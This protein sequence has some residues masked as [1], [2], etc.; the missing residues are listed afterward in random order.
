MKNRGALAGC[1]LISKK[2]GGC[3]GGGGSG[4]GALSYQAPSSDSPDSAA[5]KAYRAEISP[6]HPEISSAADFCTHN[7]TKCSGPAKAGGWGG[8]ERLQC[9]RV[10]LKCRSVLL[11]EEATSPNFLLQGGTRR[12]QPSHAESGGRESGGNASRVKVVI[13]ASL[14]KCTNEQLMGHGNGVFSTQPSL[15]RLSCE[16]QCVFHAGPFHWHQRPQKIQR[17][18]DSQ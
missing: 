7:G 9:G 14:E 10:G 16:S 11:N 6:G 2:K 5:V 13:L 17:K 18:I 12:H 8:L 15:R 4:G 1:T 3:G